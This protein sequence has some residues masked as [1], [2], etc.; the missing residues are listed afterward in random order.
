MAFRRGAPDQKGW[1]QLDIVPDQPHLGEPFPQKSEPLLLLY[2]LSDLHVC[3]SQSPLRPEYLDRW[4]DPNSPIRDQVGT[5]GTYRPHSMLTPHV[6][7][8]MVKSL[9]AVK[10]GPLSG[11]PI[12]GAIVTGDTTDNAQHNEV[13]WYLA[14]LDGAEIRPD[15]GSREKYEGVI[16]D[17]ADHYDTKYWHPHGTPAGKED[18]EPRALYG[19][20]IVPKLLDSCRAPFVAS[21]LNVPWYAVH[22]NHDALLQGTVTA[23]ESMRQEMVGNRRYAALPSSMTLADTLAAFNEVGPADFPTSSDAP[24]VLVTPDLQRRAVERGKFAALHLQSP[25]QPPGHGFSDKN[26]QK[27]TMYY[28]TEIGAV[29]LIVL[30]SVNQFGGWQGSLDED[31][32][33]WLENEISQSTKPVVLASHHPLSKMYNDYSPAIRRVC[34]EEITQM[35]LKYPQVILWLAGHEHRH[36]V[37]WIGSKIGRK[38][39]W[40][41][42]TASHVDWPQQSR[43]VEIVRGVD[44]D[45]YIGLTVVDHAAPAHYE[46]AQSPL[47]MAA[48]SR[49][50][51][52]NVWQR[53]EELGSKHPFEWAEGSPSDRNIVLRIQQN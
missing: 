8:A 22:G 29:R 28:S 4:A 44:G 31:Q 35:L 45:I 46:N 6:V 18:D 2:H 12:N 30:D 33:I 13:N 23:N 15:S 3:D 42:E 53:R 9:N 5:I 20:P 27:A 51:S 47:E 36:N 49:L 19:F 7:E 50:L 40:Q 14:L 10:I 25:G 34:F 38:G 41:I 39:F 43:T 37:E 1:R 17:G 11:H 48:L 52:A 26:V 21:G 24:Y 32:F 16:D